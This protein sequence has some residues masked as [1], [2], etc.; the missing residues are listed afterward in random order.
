M[1]AML[2]SLHLIGGYKYIIKKIRFMYVTAQSTGYTSTLAG[3][4]QYY[5]ALSGKVGRNS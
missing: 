4:C 1:R 2:F 3:Q 5:T